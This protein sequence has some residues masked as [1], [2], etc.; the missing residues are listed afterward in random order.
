[1]LLPDLVVGASSR[2]S[3]AVTNNGKG[4]GGPSVL[5]ITNVGTFQVPTLPPG[6]SATFLVN[7]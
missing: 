2:F 3:I 1:M 4:R 5:T 6:G 7:V